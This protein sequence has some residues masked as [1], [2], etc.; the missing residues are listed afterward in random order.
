V[1]LQTPGGPEIVVIL[2]AL[3]FN[4]L[5]LVGLLGGLGYFLLRIRSGGSVADR[6]GRIERAVGRL[7]AQVERVETEVGIERPAR[8]GGERGRESGDGGGD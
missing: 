4:V 7:E 5:L 1:P 3:A 8:E 2:L 6:L